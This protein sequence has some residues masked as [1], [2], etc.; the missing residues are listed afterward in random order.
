MCPTRL[1]RGF[2]F[3]IKANCL[4]DMFP[5][6]SCSASSPSQCAKSASAMVFLPV[7]SKY[8]RSIIQKTE[9]D[10]IETRQLHRIGQT[11]GQTDRQTEMDNIEHKQLHRQTEEDLIEDKRTE[12]SG[13]NYGQMDRQR[14]TKLRTDFYTDRQKRTN[15]RTDAQTDRSGQN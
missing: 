14:R 10:K 2:Y 5:G 13:Q 15:F 4:R 6:P 8:R 11:S 1:L 9:E 7:N 12:R 3:Q